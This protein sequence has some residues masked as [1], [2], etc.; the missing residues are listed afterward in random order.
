MKVS[1]G[2]NT[3]VGQKKNYQW[4]CAVKVNGVVKKVGGE[5]TH[6]RTGVTCNDNFI[7]YWN[8]IITS[9]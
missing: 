2:I 3:W 1:G 8:R 4:Y 5:M 6:K 9:L 7:Y